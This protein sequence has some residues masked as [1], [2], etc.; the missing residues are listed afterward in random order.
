MRTN[1]LE[2]QR[3]DEIGLDTTA[4]EILNRHPAVGL[5]IGV[6]RQGRLAAFH[7]E[8]LADIESRTPITEDTVFRVA[9]VTKV[10]TAIAV[11]QLRE[12]G[13]VD[14]DAPANDY[15]RR[16][17]LVPAKA[18]FG[19]PTLRH[20]LTH[21]AGIR[22]ALHWTDLLRLRDMGSVVDARQG[23]PSLTQV[24]RGGLRFDAEPGSRF[25]Y[26]NHG[27]AALGEVVEEV[28]GE[29]LDRYFRTHIFEPL[30]M[31]DTT[32]VL[33]DVP[34]SRLATAYEL[35]SRGP[36]RVGAYE[37]LTLAAGG[38]NSTPRD[39][40][41]FLAALLGGGSVDG[42]EVLQPAGLRAMFA[43]Q[44]Q[45]DP[46]VPGIGLGLFRAY[47]GEHLAL[48]H[49][50]LLPGFDA[51]ILFLPDEGLGVMAFANGARRGMHWLGPELDKIARRL[52]GVPEAAIRSDVPHHPETWGE[53]CGWYS[54][55]VAATDPAR[56][57]LGPGVEVFVRDGRL[58]IRALS[59]IPGL[60]R[61]FVLHPDDEADPYVFR[62]AFPWFGVGTGQVV[63]T[64]QPG[65]GVTAVH[66]AFGP[67]SFEKR[68]SYTNPRRGLLLGGALGA[69]ALAAGVKAARR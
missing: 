23:V 43:P 19:S 62:I 4:R 68:P 63:F 48:E 28:S 9:S 56:F 18:H 5:A 39:M 21:T 16:F 66:T 49:D 10:F 69:I 7:A 45:P 61:G 51:Q 38:V 64:R 24:Y 42:R 44:F 52:L 22:E 53:L 60:Y 15:L 1:T 50:G 36:K 8:G 20:L 27:F 13:L 11:M 3:V 54:L 40:A 14:L 12:R 31:R 41:R 32:L 2:R 35:G 46:R 47:V 34:H 6:V 58:M 33:A 55:S 29:P 57:A 26:T 25:M 67:M 65:V 59:P 17:Q 30:G 37:V